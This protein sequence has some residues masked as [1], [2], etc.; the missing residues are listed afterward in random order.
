MPLT[1][2]HKLPN[3]EVEVIIRAPMPFARGD[4]FGP[5]EIVSPLGAGGMGEVYLARDSR[6]GREVAIKVLPQAMSADVMRK[7]RFEREAKTISSLNHPNICTL[8]D[9]GS[10]DGIAF[11]VMEY[12]QGE[13]LATRLE[14][15][16]LPL[17]Q[18][19]KFGAQVAYAL[20]RAHRSG[21]V[22]RDLKPGN[23]MLTSAGAKML[24]FGLAKPTASLANGLTVTA[25]AADPMTQEGLIV[26]TFQYMSPEQIEGKDVDGRSDIFSF[27]AVLYEM[28]T[29]R[30]AFEGKS[31]LSVASAI[32]EKE[33]P[34]LSSAKSLTPTALD[35]AVA[36]CFAKNPDERWQSASDLGSELTWIA[37]RGRETSAG[38]PS[39][40]ESRA[41]IRVAWIAVVAS[42]L[43][44]VAATI[45]WRGA[46][47]PQAPMHFYAAW[48]ASARDL[49]VA[50]NGHTVAVVAYSETA[51]KNAIWIY[52]VG[53]AGAKSLSGTEG[54]AYPFWSPDGRS[55][56][57]FADSRLKRVES[58]GGP[59][60]TICDAP[61]GRGGTWSQEN[62]IVFAP[63]VNE[64]LSEIVATG[65]V[66]KKI[67]KPD[68]TKSEQGHRWPVFLPDGKHFLYLAANFSGTKNVNNILVGALEGESRLVVEA[69]ANAAYADPGYLLYY[70]NHA[71][72]A[73]AFDL[74]RFSLSGDVITLLPDIKYLPQ[75]KRAVFS[76]SFG[77]S[78]VAQGGEQEALSQPT[79]FD[80]QGKATGVVGAPDVYGNVELSPDGKS[81][82]VDKTDMETLNTD[83]WTYDLTRD[84]SKRLTF[85]P[86]ID[87]LPVWNP[88]GLSLVFG[89][90]RGMGR[91]IYMKQV[92]GT[93]DERVVANDTV[94]VYPSDWSKD[95]KYVLYS[96][97]AELWFVALSDSKAREFLKTNAVLKNG[98]FSPDGKWVAYTSNE[99]GKWEVYVT[100]F[101]DAHGKWQI[102]KG[103]GEQP[104]WRGDGKEVFYLSSDYKM[105]AAS[106]T[107]GSNF[108]AGTPVNLFQATPRPPVL[109][110]DF[111][112]YDVSRDGQRFV[113]NTPV[114][115]ADLQ[116]MSVLLN[117]ATKVH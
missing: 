101:P 108:D 75:V 112:V 103:G 17:E 57:F 20:D 4:K 3:L 117:W 24:D 109:V 8:Y 43:L 40:G 91:E 41:G 9:V 100:S 53:A 66:P 74:K 111:L 110:Y 87:A 69:G 51:R 36:K 72:V 63:D 49:A 105:M 90:N 28:L 50:P 64:G 52:E 88:D 19:L 89:S 76:V 96:R 95:G 85:D 44:L 55:I 60:E 93:Q 58:S 107:T 35:R 27:G 78:L 97:G 31:Q 67:T 102:S 86:S 81:L 99:T 38:E 22:H 48:Q 94:N 70:R 54:A 11:L 6:L 30:R 23:I 33:P 13:T 83:I 1:A 37:E 39:A 2:L 104:R 80:R 29:G 71:L 115:Q 42:V 79:W 84:S 62:L 46:K 7:Q 68:A 116:P 15:G 98:Q 21:V 12:V 56:A 82:A 47:S 113:I 32:L 73:Q 65:G 59:V 92:G 45:W 18:A 16:P 25:A 10:H 61:S 77:G 34:S 106:V 26:G 114:K 14:K 5:Y